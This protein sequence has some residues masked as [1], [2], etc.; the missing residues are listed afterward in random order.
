M[1]HLLPVHSAFRAETTVRKKSKESETE[2]VTD[3]LY[4]EAET[5]VSEEITTEAAEETTA[6]ETTEEPVTEAVKENAEPVKTVKTSAKTVTAKVVASKPD[7]VEFQ[8]NILQNY[9]LST[10]NICGAQ[11]AM[12]SLVGN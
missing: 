11:E 4:D 10:T 5:A 2:L 8:T 7:C 6:A 12:A 3:L 1:Q 9:T